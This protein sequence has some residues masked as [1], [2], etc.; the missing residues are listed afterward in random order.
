MAR[1]NVE[2]Q[3]LTDPR[4]Y[5]FGRS[6]G[7]SSRFALE[8]G[9]G[10]MEVIWNELTERWSE[11]A[12]PAAY[13]VTHET[14]QILFKSK[15]F[16]NEIGAKLIESQLASET[17]FG[18]RIHGTLGRIEWL[19]RRRAAARDNGKLGGR[20]PNSVN[21]LSLALS[22]ALPPDPPLPSVERD[23][24][25]ENP[26]SPLAGVRVARN[27]NY[28]PG[29]LTAWQA[30]PHHAHRSSK[31]QSAAVWKKLRLEHH[32]AGVLRWIEACSADE[33][34]IKE[35]GSLVPGFQ[36][37][38]KRPDFT[39]DPPKNGPKPMQ[40]SEKGRKTANATL[41]WLRNQAEEPQ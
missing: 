38:L 15:R 30:Y 26:P 39:E 31:P 41:N 23:P 9:R 34:W 7:C 28:P 2:Q 10:I 40:L 17:E 20:K 8:A 33:D 5:K 4:F 35:S 32:T 1:I 24:S 27:G 11:E 16:R 21:P 6:L 3:A 13:C 18:L 14:L 22:P 29:F 37:W 12:G 36:V 19:N 25:E